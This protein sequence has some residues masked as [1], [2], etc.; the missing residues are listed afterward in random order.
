MPQIAHIRHYVRLA[1]MLGASADG[2]LTSP[3]RRDLIEIDVLPGGGCVQVD[4]RRDGGVGG[5][6]HGLCER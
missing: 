5:R 2:P 4:D 1:L 6:C 3:T